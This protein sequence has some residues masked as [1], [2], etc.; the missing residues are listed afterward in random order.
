MLATRSGCGATGCATPN[1]V[2]AA[3]GSSVQLQVSR[4]AAPQEAA[5]IYP[6]NYWLS[7]LEPPA[8]SEFQTPAAG[9]G[10]AGLLTGASQIPAT[11]TSQAAWISQF[12][13]GCQLCHQVG[14]TITR[15]KTAEMFDLVFR[16]AA[17]MNVTAE[18]LGRERLVKVLGDWS[19][20]IAAGEVPPQ[21][22]RPAGVERNM[23]ITQ[24]GWGDTFTYAHDE[25]AT[26]KRHPTM[27]AHGPI[28]GVDLGNDHLLIPDPKTHKVS[29]IKVPTKDGFA[30]PWCKQTYKALGS[31]ARL[32]DGFSSLGC[33]AEDGDSGNADKYHNPANPHNPMLDDTGKVWMTTQIRRQWAEDLPDF[34]KDKSEIAKNRHHRQLGYYDTKT[35]E[36][37]VFELPKT[38]TGSASGNTMRIHSNGTVWLNSIAANQVIRLDP[39]T[40]QFTVF[41]VPAGI[42]AGRTANPYGMAISGDDKIWFVENA[43]NQLGRIDPVTGKIDEFEI[44]VKNPVA[45]KGGM[46]S[47]GNV[48]VGLHGAGKLMKVDYKTTKMTVYTPPTDDA[49]VYSVQ[50]DTKSHL[51]WFSE[52]HVDKIARFDPATEA[53]TE[54]P[55]ADA[56]SDPRRIEID[57]NNPNRIWWSGDL[58]GRMGYV[59]LLK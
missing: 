50:G 45:R 44:P 10:G 33:P 6:A 34:C 28:Y 21:P 9:K 22:P 42:K 27:N 38:K 7:L 14:S 36:F 26:D 8:E 56:E 59:E 5:A 51:V 46:D 16:K 40:K 15:S 58:S 4:A 19:A 12:K 37:N 32:P 2:Q 39:A 17:S 3:P 49:G 35:K 24:W 53:F 55:L 13:L 54:F 25:I 29:T 47:E 57:A 20:R 52:Q 1:K 48:W 30:T 11:Y 41:E 31:E 43:M 18:S 23:V